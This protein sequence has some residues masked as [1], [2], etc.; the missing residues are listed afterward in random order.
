MEKCKRRRT[1]GPTPCLMCPG[2]CIGA[3]GRLFSRVVST[4]ALWLFLLCFACS[5]AE[6]AVKAKGKAHVWSPPLTHADLP[7]R[8]AL[9][10]FYRFGMYKGYTDAQVK[11]AGKAQGF[12]ATPRQEAAIAR[13]FANTLSP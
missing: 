2:R 7:Y 1:D 10:R 13:C 6:A 11:A 12:T 8:C 5:A 9:I 4:A 3:Q